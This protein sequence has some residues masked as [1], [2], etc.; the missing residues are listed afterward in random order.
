MPKNLFV[1]ILALCPLFACA[2][3]SES[4]AVL[5]S[6]REIP[7]VEAQETTRPE[8][9]KRGILRFA[10]TI[11]QPLDHFD[12]QSPKFR[13]RLVL[14]HRGY[15][16]PMVLQT[17]GYQIFGEYL[18]RL[19]STFRTNQL[20]VEHRFFG[21]SVP[22][23]TDWSKLTVRQSAED[24]HR[25]V[26][27]LREK[28]NKPWVGTGASKGGMTSVY[29]RRFYPEDLAGTVADVAPLSFTRDDPRYIPFV[30]EVGGESYAACRAK[31]E[32]LQLALLRRRYEFLPRLNGTFRI[33]GDKETAFEHAVIE[34]P[35][36]FW[37]Y[38]VPSGCVSLPGPGDSAEK[39]WASLNKI[40]NPH[41]LADARLVAFQ[42][43]FYQ[44]AAELGGPASKTSH[45]RELMRKDYRLEQYLP[46]AQ[47]PGYTD[48]TM[49]DVRAWVRES[50]ERIAFVYGA[51]DPWTA[52][53]FNE[54]ATGRENRRYVVPEKNH[55]ANFTHLP[56]T[57][58]QEF[59]GL[60]AR[61]FGKN[62]VMEA[63]E[64]GEISL[65][66][67][68]AKAREELRLIP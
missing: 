7:G 32:A 41:S 2:E 1:L 57:D 59:H 11:E 5:Q 45:L 14:F 56:K 49:Q 39:L 64:D 53:A 63:L 67:Y 16:E 61:W 52:G 46:T 8:D 43:Y 65:E 40:N 23:P 60:L 21:E 37:Q 47:D 19:A 15:K 3:S 28:Y 4:E 27:A 24:F 17:S 35:F 31:L 62:A 50:A 13:Q 6:L 44:A 26:Q 9:T 36:A 20:Q 33:L 29:H 68:E 55:S 30:D 54:I 66:E 10:I 34:L 58:K 12:P 48:A 42:P 22:K 18:S 25:I 38:S 51:F